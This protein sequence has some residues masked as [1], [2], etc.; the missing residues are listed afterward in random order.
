MEK[1]MIDLVFKD[2][3]HK[4]KLLYNSLEQYSDN[5]DIIEILELFIKS[6][7]DSLNTFDCFISACISENGPHDE[8]TNHKTITGTDDEDSELADYS[9][10]AK[11]NNNNSSL[12]CLPPLI[13]NNSSHKQLQEV[14]SEIAKKSE[15][16]PESI[17]VIREFDDRFIKSQNFIDEITATQQKMEEMLQDYKKYSQKYSPDPKSQFKESAKHFYEMLQDYKKYSQ[18]YSPDPKFRFK[19]S[20]KRFYE[21]LFSNNQLQSRT[22]NVALVRVLNSFN[23]NNLDKQLRYLF[24]STKKKPLSQNEKGFISSRIFLIK[25]GVDL[26]KVQR[27]LLPEEISLEKTFQFI[28]SIDL[29]HL[30]QEAEDKVKLSY[31]QERQWKSFSPYEL[32]K[33]KIDAHLLDIR[34]KY[35][36]TVQSVTTTPDDQLKEIINDFMKNRL[37]PFIEREM[38]EIIEYHEKTVEQDRARKREDLEQVRQELLDLA[39]L[40]PIKVIEK[41]EKFDPA[42]HIKMRDEHNSQLEDMVILRKIREG[43]FCI[44]TN[45]VIRPASVEVNYNFSG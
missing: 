20:A 28:D 45:T 18:K 32:F 10:N 37:L 31:E 26:V 14:A 13:D 17:N 39:T 40:K 25:D 30:K 16:L 9:M 4:K 23:K 2:M 33:E 44:A 36:D 8:R 38:D 12:C 24:P 34:K 27:N 21:T 41:S 22:K 35:E 11:E 6:Y 1:E 3:D 19:E 29:D 5:K 7:Q 42:K 43:Y 15:E